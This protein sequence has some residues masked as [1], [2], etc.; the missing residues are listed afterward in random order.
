MLPFADSIRI[1]AYTL[2]AALFASFPALAQSGPIGLPYQFT[3]SEN[4]DVTLSPDGKQ[5]VV[6]S[7]IA[8]KEQLVRMNID[9]SKPAQITTDVADHEDPAWSPDG[10]KIAF[11]L[12]RDGLEQIHIMNPDGSG[13]DANHA[14]R[15]AY[16]S[17]VMVA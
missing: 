13:V 12:I 9:R 5:L 10:K 15:A 16:H 6:L 4:S 11:V 7:V 1:A 2:S 17:S 3:H 8:G 14:Q